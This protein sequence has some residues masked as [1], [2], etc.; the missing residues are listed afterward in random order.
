[1]FKLIVITIISLNIFD[2]SI[3]Q[4]ASLNV[5]APVSYDIYFNFA[6]S[7]YAREFTGVAQIEFE[8][9]VQSS[10]LYLNCKNLEIDSRTANIT[11]DL[12]VEGIIEQ[13]G[14]EV[15]EIQLS[16]ELEPAKRYTIELDFTGKVNSD[17]SGIFDEY[18]TEDY[19]QV[20]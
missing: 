19:Q 1:M 15:C 12:V 20:L 9:L 8:C 3:G 14:T 18:Y 10:K 6:D 7:R 17:A 16:G 5:A 11:E 2:P 4:E 13:N